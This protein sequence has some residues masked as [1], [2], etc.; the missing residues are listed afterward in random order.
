MAVSTTWGLPVVTTGFDS[1]LGGLWRHS[2]DL[3]ARD[4]FRNG[5]SA[6]YAA[7]RKGF[8]TRDFNWERTVRTCSL[9]R[10]ACA[11]AIRVLAGVRASGR[12]RL[13]FF[14]VVGLGVCEPADR[15]GRKPSY[16]CHRY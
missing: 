12:L 4:C 9:T 2:D 3:P 14:I 7:S 13:F 1:A 8:E 11:S 15:S 5:A 16:I 10:A 6:N